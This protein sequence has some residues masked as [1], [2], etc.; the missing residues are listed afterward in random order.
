MSKI[1]L[2]VQEAGPAPRVGC[3][4]CRDGAESAAPR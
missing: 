1:A 4:Y 3:E 2:D